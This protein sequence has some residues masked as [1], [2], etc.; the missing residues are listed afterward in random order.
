M[1]VIDW[2]PE[3]WSSEPGPN[4][5][6]IAEY[7]SDLLHAL[8][9][10]SVLATCASAEICYSR[11]LRPGARFVGFD[12]LTLRS[13]P[14]GT[15]L[16]SLEN[17]SVVCDLP[18]RLWRAVADYFSPLTMHRGDQV[19]DFDNEPGLREDAC[20]IASTDIAPDVFE[21]LYG[22]LR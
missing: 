1:L 17:A 13:S 6:W 20:W 19:I 15:S 21:R 16:V 8:A 5:V 4:W 7:P 10:F 9:V 11:C 14:A 22:H 12:S 18:G 2:S 3:R